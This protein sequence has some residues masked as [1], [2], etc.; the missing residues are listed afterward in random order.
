MTRIKKQNKNKAI[1]IKQ[2][3]REEDY[4]IALNILLDE[5]L[6][7]NSTKKERMNKIDEIIKKIEN[8]VK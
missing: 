3:Q 6:G 5:L 2:K 4:N 8:S 7:E 1:D